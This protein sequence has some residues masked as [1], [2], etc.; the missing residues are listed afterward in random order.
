MSARFLFAHLRVYRKFLAWTSRFLYEYI[1]MVFFPSV[2][3]VV[4]RHR[5]PRRPRCVRLLWS[6]LGPC[7]CR[8][9][10][11]LTTLTWEILRREFLRHGLV[12]GALSTDGLQ[13]APL[14]G[15]VRRLLRGVVLRCSAPL[16]VDFL[17]VFG[18]CAGSLLRS[19]R[20][21]RRVVRLVSQR[22][23]HFVAWVDDR[24]HLDEYFVDFVFNSRGLR[25]PC[26]S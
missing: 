6:N 23:P 17:G 21:L 11:V 9:R 18:K 19:S 10:V 20:S 25:R 13:H 24:T 16:G 2:L 26:W 4:C 12:L 5:F 1:L 7:R 15:T 14:L 22:S 8:R 3:F